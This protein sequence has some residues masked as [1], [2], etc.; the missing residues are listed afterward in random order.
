MDMQTTLAFTIYFGILVII[1]L[2]ATR[3][4]KTSADFL[5][6]SRSLNYWITAI[7]AQASDMSPWLFMGFPAV[8]WAHGLIEGWVVIGCIVGNFLSWHFVAPKLRTA[9]EQYHALTL[10]TYFSRRFDDHRGIL[11]ILTAAISLIFFT[12]YI[13]A[14]LRGMGMV[15]E[16]CFGLDYTLAI[17]ISTLAVI[18]YTAIGGFLAVAWADLFQ[19]TFLLIMVVL[20]PLVALSTLPGGIADVLQ[21]AQSKNISLSL[22]PDFSFTGLVSALVIAAGWGLG[23]FGQPHILSKFMGI[24]DVKEMSKA[25]MVGF[26]WQVVVLSAAVAI[27]LIDSS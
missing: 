14:G 6:G 24:G 10:S 2:A 9:T 23:Y 8:V 21:A 18:A 15:S 22:L 1:G 13:S 7:S 17:T 19:G 11:R 4:Q 27:G 16:T 12:F 3:K 26:S 5:L 25:K 20:V